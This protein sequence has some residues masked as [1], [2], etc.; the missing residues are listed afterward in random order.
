MIGRDSLRELP[1]QGVAIRP[2]LPGDLDRV[3][4]IERL[5][6]SHPWSESVFL[7]CFQENYRL[8]ALAREELVLGYAIV[9]YMVDEAHLLNIC[10]HPDIR[11]CG[12]GR[13]LLRHALAEAAHDGMVMMI[14]EVRESNHG[15]AA[16]YLSEG[17]E[18]IGRRPGYYPN[19]ATRE[20]A[21]VM[22]LRFT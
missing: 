1:L 4:E 5:S 3:Q 6:H 9:N 19:G 16:L 12:A 17:F 20:T 10:I 7:D 11:G 21:R 15:A 13:Y 22:S 8:W 2:L 14:L 18:E